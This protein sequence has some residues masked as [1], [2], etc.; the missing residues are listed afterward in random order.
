MKR[1]LLDLLGDWRKER[2]ADGDNWLSAA[3]TGFFV[4]L[5]PQNWRLSWWLIAR[6]NSRQ[7]LTPSWLCCL[8]IPFIND[9]FFLG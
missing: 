9:G 7:D 8:L 1:V 5:I 3:A 6:K 2:R 4:P